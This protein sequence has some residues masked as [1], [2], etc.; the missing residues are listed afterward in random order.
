MLSNALSAVWPNLNQPEEPRTTNFNYNGLAA[1]TAGSKF[2]SL[3]VVPEPSALLL[4]LGPLSA[5]GSRR[6]RSGTSPWWAAR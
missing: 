5:W 1:Q 6:R 4:G 3:T 2:L